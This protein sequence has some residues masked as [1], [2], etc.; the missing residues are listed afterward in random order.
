MIDRRDAAMFDARIPLSRPRCPRFDL[1]DIERGSRIGVS[2]N[3]PEI[4]GIGT[5]HSTRFGTF[6]R[7]DADDTGLVLVMRWDDG[8]EQHV[9]VSRVTYVDGKVVP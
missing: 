9:H 8:T 7:L 6:H 1:S 4:D 5:V 3:S 2:V